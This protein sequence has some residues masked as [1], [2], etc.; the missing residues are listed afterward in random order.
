MRNYVG[1]KEVKALPMTMGEA[2]DEGLLQ[3]GRVPKATERD[4]P[5]YKVLYI[6]GYVSWSP[7]EPFEQAYRLNDSLKDKLSI[8]KE[9]LKNRYIK[10][11]LL[12][13]SDQFKEIKDKEQK[14]LLI[15]QHSVMKDYL[16]VLSERIDKL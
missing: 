6:D 7:K 12:I 13:Q 11:S 15:R 1:T 2:Y 4:N 14:D 9:D 16:N 5:G 10:I 8:E 3:A